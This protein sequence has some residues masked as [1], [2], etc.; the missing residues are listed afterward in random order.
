MLDPH[1][2]VS[3]RPQDLFAYPSFTYRINLHSYRARRD[4][5]AGVVTRNVNSLEDCEEINRI[6][7]RCGMVPAPVDVLWENQQKA[8]VVTVLVAESVETGQIVGT[9]TGVDHERLFRSEERSVGKEC[10]STCRSRWSP[11][12]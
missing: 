7:V 3:R 8:R 1:F 9:V 4:T 5:I 12:H 2:L 11:N 10:V 6:Y